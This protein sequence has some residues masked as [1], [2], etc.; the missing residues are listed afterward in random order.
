M[1]VS[2]KGIVDTPCKDVFFIMDQVEQ[3][4]KALV[5]PGWKRWMQTEGPLFEMPTV[6]LVANSNAAKVHFTIEGDRRTLWVFFRC[7]EDNTTYAHQSISISLGAWGDSCSILRAVLGSLSMLGPCYLEESD[8]NNVGY[9]RLAEMGAPSYLQA[10]GLRT[11]QATPTFLQTWVALFEAGF[12]KSDNF[13]EC[14][15]M[16]RDE[17]RACLEADFS[18]ACALI[19]AKVQTLPA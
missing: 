1:S 16:T 8:A 10:V 2:T 15:G 3:A 6:E 9:Q 13:K 17:A 7:D 18:D 4:V 12:L 14:I 11:S 19:E 5:R